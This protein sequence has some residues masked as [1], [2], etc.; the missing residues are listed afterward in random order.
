MTKIIVELCQNHKG[1][2][3]LLGR[4]V[5]A[6][7]K[8]GAD[9]V[10]MQSI[11]S[12]DLTKRAP[13]E[14][15][16]ISPDGTVLVIKRPYGAEKERLSKLDLTIDDHLFFIEKC[17]KYGVI[18]MTT[19]F[20]RNRILEIAKLPWPYKVIK[21]ASYDCASF[22]MLEELTKHF[23]H[24]IV[25]TGA[26]YDDEIE[27]AA[28]LIKKSGKKLTMLHCVTSYPNTLEMANIKRL[29]W[30]RKFVPEVGWSDHT[31]IERDRLIASKA[32]IYFG[33]DIVERHFTILEKD[34]TKDGPVSI[35]PALL[36]ELS[37]F[38]KLSKKAKLTNL[39]RDLKDWEK[40]LGVEAREMTHTEKL[41]RDYYRGRFASK[42]G[43]KWVYNWEE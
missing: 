42:K 1:D 15:G 26:S 9:Y 35:T 25:S 33:A 27:K 34:E 10:K 37:D 2:R 19:I 12:D 18:P 40:V 20:A 29:D 14:E 28:T 11:F 32:A 31:L 5:E 8:S 3:E 7:A 39:R 6:A 43:G 13:F 23:D 24:I 4:M 30:L 17:K 16:K 36:K 38:R 41:N 21:V 22:P